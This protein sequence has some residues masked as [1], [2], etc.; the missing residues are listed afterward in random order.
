MVSSAQK[1]RLGIF[2]VII[3]VLLIFFLVMVA[4]NKIMEKRDIYYIKYEDTSVSGL[5]IGGPVRY[6]GI[7]IGRVEEINIDKENVA[8][9]IVTVSVKAG[10]PLKKDIDAS[11]NPIGITG[12]L[13]IEISGGTNKA[14]FLKPKS[15]IPAGESTFQN[16]SGKAEIIMGKLEILLNN[17]NSIT[18]ETNRKKL[19][20]I[21]TS[22]DTLVNTNIE[23]I[24]NIITNLDVI[25]AEISTISVSLNEATVR[26][27][28]IIQT[29]K[30][31]NI[32]SNTDKI[33]AELSKLDLKKLVKDLDNAVT[34][35][36]L[37]LSHLDTTHME[38]KQDILDTIESLRETIDNLN[39]FSRQ[40]IEDPSLLLKS[41]RK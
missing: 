2:I 23:P 28:D 1:F 38:S 11:L 24:G 8:N 17:L 25:S 3:S 12:L 32:V 21:L 20:N 6:Y 41:R 26:I 19:T 40:I 35:I 9:V 22:I 30:I 29:G 15:F 27:N 36:D 14:E 16:I 4:G 34:Q 18:D 10:T 13:Q 33:T 31:D 37:T 7:A 39:E 5:Q